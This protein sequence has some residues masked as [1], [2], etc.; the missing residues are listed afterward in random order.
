MYF[1]IDYKVNIQNV[2]T[3][4]IS[5]TMYTLDKI[6]NTFSPTFKAWQAFITTLFK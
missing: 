1:Y 6:L 2:Y 5:F 3:A 4:N